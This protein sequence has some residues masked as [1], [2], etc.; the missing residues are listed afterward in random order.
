M[1]ALERL[2]DEGRLALDVAAALDVEAAGLLE[3]LPVLG[4]DGGLSLCGHSPATV[5][6]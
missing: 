6:A 2:G 3:F 4:V 5:R 1:A